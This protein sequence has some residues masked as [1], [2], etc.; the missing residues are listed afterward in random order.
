MMGLK[1]AYVLGRSAFER[2]C[3]S[4]TVANGEKELDSFTA[5]FG[6]ES[7]D[8]VLAN[9]DKSMPVKRIGGAVSGL[10]Q[11]IQDWAVGDDDFLCD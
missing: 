9:T 8:D 5:I 1:L 3:R 4:R 7:L 2:F 10:N 6:K 11:E